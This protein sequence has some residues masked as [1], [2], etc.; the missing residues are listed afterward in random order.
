MT[1]PVDRESFVEFLL[2]AKRHTYAAGGGAS[3]AVV[4]PL[5]PG[6]HQLDYSDGPFFYRDVYYGG[7]YFVGQET[8]YYE[9]QPVWS[10]VYAGGFTT[11][12]QS[13]EEEGRIGAFLQAAM[14]QVTPQRPYR[15]PDELRQPPYIYTDETHGDL[16]RFWGLETITREGV[17]VYD[18]RYQG[19]VLR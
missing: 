2:D 7:A 4:A 18:L 14:R 3:A 10:M 17:L 11:A 16:A 1:L 9:Q 15:G 8:V 12:V 5:L 19:G 6:S 13:G